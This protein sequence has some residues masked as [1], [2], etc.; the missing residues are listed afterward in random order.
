MNWETYLALGDSITK[1][2]RTYLGYPELVGHSLNTHLSSQWNVVNHSVCGFKAID[3]ARSIDQNFSSLK[4]KRAC[5]STILVGTND[6]KERTA[7]ADFAI[8][9]DQVIL[10]ARLLTIGGNVIVIAIPSFH[11]GITYPYSINMNEH[12]ASLNEHIKELSARRGV[13][14]VSIDHTAE[15]FTDGVHLNDKGIATFSTQLA[16]HIL[17]DKGM[18]LT[19]F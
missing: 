7:P 10:K 9:L 5:I 11:K 6:I 17:K 16:G 14:M 15:D 8:A 3:L 2:A 13:R 4:E 18:T 1:G 12:V 19:A